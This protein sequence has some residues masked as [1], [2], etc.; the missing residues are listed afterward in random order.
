MRRFALYWV[1]ILVSLCDHFKLHSCISSN[2]QTRAS[3]PT[4]LDQSSATFYLLPTESHKVFLL[5]QPPLF[6][7]AC[8]CS[9]HPRQWNLSPPGCPEPPMSL[10]LRRLSVVWPILF[11]QP[12]LAPRALPNCL[13]M[14]DLSGGS[15]GNRNIPINHQETTARTHTHTHTHRNTN[16]DVHPKRTHTFRRAPRAHRASSRLLSLSGPGH[17]ARSSLYR[18]TGARAALHRGSSGLCAEAL[19][20]HVEPLDK[21]FIA[22]MNEPVELTALH[23]EK[24]PG[25]VWYFAKR[26]NCKTIDTLLIGSAGEYAHNSAWDWAEYYVC[27]ASFCSS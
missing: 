14:D 26:G 16:G 21:L 15:R 9:I 13:R 17:S 1:P 20:P 3:S 22:I 6:L 5:Q 19:P 4:S 25:F 24:K 7:T 27:N 2:L 10:S 23:V 18:L 12:S 8:Y 11:S